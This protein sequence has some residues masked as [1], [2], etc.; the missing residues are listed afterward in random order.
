MWVALLHNNKKF[1][2]TKDSVQRSE[3]VLIC[4]FKLKTILYINTT[5]VSYFNVTLM[6][7]HLILLFKTEQGYL[8]AG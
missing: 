1:L 5:S 6:S 7:V 4:N 3:M 8:L 2:K